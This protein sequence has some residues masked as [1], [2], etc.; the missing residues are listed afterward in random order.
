MW[1]NITRRGEPIT[2]TRRKVVRLTVEWTGDAPVDKYV[3]WLMD[4][5][6]KG[7]YSGVTKVTAIELQGEIIECPPGFT[8]LDVE[9]FA[10][11]WFR[12]W[13]PA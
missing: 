4:S 9:T 12:R 7:D 8:P 1:R 5:L 10:A 13:G 11:K 3:P 2:D 6:E